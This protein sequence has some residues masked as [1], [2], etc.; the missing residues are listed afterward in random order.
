MREQQYLLT[1]RQLWDARVGPH[2]ESDFYDM[3]RFRKG[4]SSLNEIDVALLGDVSGLNVLH[5]QCHFGQDSLSLSRMGA[6]VTGLDFSPKAIDTARKLATELGLDTRFVCADVYDAASQ[7]GEPV[8]LV[9]TSYGVLGWLP[10]LSRWAR[11]VSDSLKSGGEL[12]LLEFHPV[13][14][15]FDDEFQSLKYSYFQREAIVE[16]EQ[17]TYAD[18]NAPLQLESISWNH[19]LSAVFQA[20]K[21]ADMELLHFAEFDFSPYPV[22]RNIVETKAGQYQIKG[23]EGILPMVYGLRARKKS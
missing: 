8:D 4:K 18:P 9:F 17:G 3:E 7:V 5:L 20:L 16:L 12:V 21:A 1:N 13:V 2:L 10:D 15:M 6:K 19:G 14:W 11:A 23:L 22:F